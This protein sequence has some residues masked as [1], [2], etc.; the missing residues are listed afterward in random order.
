MDA[1]DKLSRDI[2]NL[3]KFQL[4]ENAICAKNQ[5]EALL[6]AKL[7]RQQLKDVCHAIAELNKIIAV[8]IY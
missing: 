2:D 6:M 3:S 1:L 8:D 4:R 5:Y 7:D